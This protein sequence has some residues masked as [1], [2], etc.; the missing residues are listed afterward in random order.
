MTSK[1]KK[2]KLLLWKNFLIQ[3]RH[4]M[5]TVFEIILP[6]IFASCLLVVRVMVDVEYHKEDRRY[7]PMP[8]DN[9]NVIR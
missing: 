8:L 6:I 5:Q 7:L 1:V 4:L 2:L 3:R 9:L